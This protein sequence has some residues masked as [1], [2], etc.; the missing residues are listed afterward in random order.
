MAS[1]KKS[2]ADPLPCGQSEGWISKTSF[3]EEEKKET[4]NLFASF[5]FR[6]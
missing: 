6:V 5:C 2:I 4:E 3:D 1:K